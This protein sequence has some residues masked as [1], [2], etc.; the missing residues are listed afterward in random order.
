MPQITI[1][2]QPECP[3][4]EFAK[5]F[6]TECGFTFEIK[7]IKKDQTAYN[8]LIKKYQSYS[9][10]TFVINNDQVITGFDMEKLKAALDLE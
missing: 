7:D 5:R 10:P 6:L 8:E 9:T 3:P 2:T 4:C 1:Y